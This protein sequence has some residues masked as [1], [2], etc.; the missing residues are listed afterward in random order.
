M[1]APNPFFLW[2]LYKLYCK[3]FYKKPENEGKKPKGCLS[4]LLSLYLNILAV[5]LL[6]TAIAFLIHL[7]I[8]AVA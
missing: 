5:A 8:N 6:L 4:W 7:I 1:A 2:L 3:R